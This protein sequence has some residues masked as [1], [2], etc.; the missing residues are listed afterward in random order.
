MNIIKKLTIAFSMFFCSILMLSAVTPVQAALFDNSVKQACK[1]A[2]LSNRNDKCD[3][4][5]AKTSV[6]T[7]LQRIINLLTVIVGIAAVIVII[8]NGLKF[9]TSSGD[10]NNITSARN[11]II[12][13]IVGLIIV[14][15]AQ[16]IVRFILN[17]IY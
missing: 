6:G 7:T 17:Q 10:S 16:V 5:N 13:A 3:S 1:G 9:I 15:L 4:E 2:N 12:Y 11:G 8:I 14:A